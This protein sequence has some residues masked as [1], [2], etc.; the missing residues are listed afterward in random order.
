MMCYVTGGLFVVDLYI[1]L[2]CIRLMLLINK[3]FVIYF[4]LSFVLVKQW[5]PSTP[6]ERV[7]RNYS[8]LS[9]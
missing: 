4:C 3:Y 5:I 8:A 9:R 7:K 1:L 2:Y 6:E